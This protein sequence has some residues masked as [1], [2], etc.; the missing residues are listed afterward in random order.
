[1]PYW[2]SIFVSTSTNYFIS[3]DKHALFKYS[4]SGSTNGSSQGKW[5]FYLDET[6]EYAQ[7]EKDCAKKIAMAKF[8]SEWG[9]IMVKGHQPGH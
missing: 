5:Y 4:I 2:L 3:L 9:I 6:W 7:A 8:N 1:M